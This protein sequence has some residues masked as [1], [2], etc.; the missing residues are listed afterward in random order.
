MGCL[1]RRAVAFLL[2]LGGSPLACFQDDGPNGGGSASA[3]GGS[4]GGSSGGGASD[5]CLAYAEKVVACGIAMSMSAADLQA[6]CDAAL[7]MFVDP[8]RELYLDVLT[9]YGQA[10]CDTLTDGLACQAEVNVFQAL[11]NMSTDS[12]CEAYGQKTA[13]CGIEGQDAATCQAALDAA[14]GEWCKAATD[15]LYACRAALS[16]D[17]FAAGTGCEAKAQDVMSA[18][19]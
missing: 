5:A 6:L 12:T 3:G 15:D 19:D 7:E 4:S 2:I 8:C 11:C 13:Q 9:C 1:N 10:K 17:E 16:C 18:C 14:V